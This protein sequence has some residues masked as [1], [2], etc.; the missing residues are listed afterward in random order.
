MNRARLGRHE[1]MLLSLA[2]RST[3]WVPVMQDNE[4]V[5]QGIFVRQ[6][7]REKV[8]ISEQRWDQGNFCSLG[9]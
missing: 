7:K 6:N 8:A 5:H 1:V 2:Q 4:H 3:D 9:V